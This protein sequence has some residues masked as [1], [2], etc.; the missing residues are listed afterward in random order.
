[1][2]NRA[3]IAIVVAIVAIYLLFSSI[4]VLNERQQAIVLRFGEI[5]R[6]E[7][8]PGLNFKLP[9]NFVE[10]VQI[11][12][13]RILRYE[14]EDLRVQV[15]GGKFYVVDAFITYRI[16]DPTRFRESVFGSIATAEQRIDTRLENALRDV[17]GLRQFEDALSE[18]RT[19]MMREVQAQV[20]D[21]LEVIGL[22]VVDVRII[23]TDLTAEVSQQTFDRMKAERLAEAARLRAR[24]QELAQTLRAQADRQAVEIVATAQR[25]ADILRGEGDAERNRIFAEAFTKDAEFFEFYR[26][27]QSYRSALQGTGTTML[28]SP[29]SEFFQYFR[30]DSVGTFENVPDPQTPEATTPVPQAEASEDQPTGQ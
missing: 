17:Y 16:V 20:S 3:I 4:F 19:S 15:S 24:G 9:T 22:E 13:D 14:L 18:E 12:D 11:I 2:G 30:S 27:M 5:V 10:T 1:M 23:R 26:S 21:E 8:E 25:D 28:L 6:V 7:T 29:N